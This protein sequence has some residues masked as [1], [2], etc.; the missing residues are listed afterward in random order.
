MAIVAGGILGLGLPAAVRAAADPGADTLIILDGEG[1]AN[2]RIQ[3]VDRLWQA[4]ETG[5]VTRAAAR[6]TLKQVLWKGGAP[7]SLRLHALG[8]LLSDHTPEGQSDNRKFLRLRLPT[9]SQ[10]PVIDEV[11]KQVAA[12]GAED[13]SWRELDGALVRSYAR[14]VPTPTDAERPERGALLA[15]HPGQTIE[16]VVFDVYVT[17]DGGRPLP[18][19]SSELI[20]KQRQAAWELLGRL[21]PTGS[22]RRQLLATVPSDDPAVKPIARAAAELRIVPVTGSELAWLNDLIDTKDPGAAGWWSS[23]QAAVGQL[24]SAQTEGLQ[25]RHIEPVRWAAKNHAAWLAADR[26]ALLDEL[27]KRL[28]PRR[29]WRKSEGLGVGAIMSRELLSD[30]QDQLA[31]GDVLAIL[32]IDESIKDPRVVDSLFVQAEADRNDSSAEYGG[33]IFATDAVPMQL[34]GGTLKPKWDVDPARP[35]FVVHGYAPRPAQRVNDRTFVASNDMFAAEGAGGRALAHYHFHA[36]TVNNA[37]YAGPGRGDFDYAATHGRSCVVFTS[38]R[39][40]V[41]NAD[42]YQ[43]STGTGGGGEG[44]QIDLGEVVANR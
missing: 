18:G 42:Y 25:L 17:P 37:D 26:A 13:P 33:A 14:R 38:V 7:S 31:W 20:E 30:W 12:A 23:A 9:E 35:G 16:Q 29:K 40:G 6:D 32:V 28:E 5:E 3:A 19:Q 44:V 1:G 21:D 8:K 36:Q 41:L 39:P 43:R 27:S 2:K 15:L 34:V 24:S 11:C 22:T 4:V 10:W